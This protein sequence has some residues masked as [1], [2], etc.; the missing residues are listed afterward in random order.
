MSQK[1]KV[2]VEVEFELPP[3]VANAIRNGDRVEQRL[4]TWL[5]VADGFYVMKALY[6]AVQTLPLQ[7]KEEKIFTIF[8]VFPNGKTRTLQA[9]SVTTVQQVAKMIEE[10]EGVPAGE[11]YLRHKGKL[12]WGARC[13]STQFLAESKM[14]EVSRYPKRPNVSILIR[15]CSSISATAAQFSS[16]F[17]T[18]Q[19]WDL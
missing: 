11:Q 6:D 18:H 14:S 15:P 16:R 5:K 8:V 10:K 19:S 7:R 17:G 12:L 3:E 1:V 2:K 9:T 4:E 13:D